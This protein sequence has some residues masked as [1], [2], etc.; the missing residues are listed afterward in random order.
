LKTLGF[1]RLLLNMGPLV[2]PFPH[3][4]KN[5]F[6]FATGRKNQ[7]FLRPGK[8]YIKQPGMIKL[9]NAVFRLKNTALVVWRKKPVNLFVYTVL[10]IEGT[11]HDHRKFQPLRL[12]NGHN[13][14]ISLGYGII[15]I[16]IFILSG[17][18][19]QIKKAVEELVFHHFPVPC[20][21]QIHVV[22]GHERT[23]QG[24]ELR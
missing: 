22:I 12:V 4:I 18:K 24:R 8:G 11:D 9:R 23:Y 16:L 13:L 5:I 19:K 14:N 21:Y 17:I 10:L 15:V 20:G 7:H 2:K 6:G 1:Q 3:N